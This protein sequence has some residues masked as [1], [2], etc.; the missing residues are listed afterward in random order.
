MPKIF[1]NS[2]TSFEDASLSNSVTP[3]VKMFNKEETHED[4]DGTM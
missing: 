3:V 2:M 4:D 1:A